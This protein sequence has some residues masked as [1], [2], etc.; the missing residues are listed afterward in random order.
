MA[1]EIRGQDD[2]VLLSVSDSGPGIPE[3]QREKIFGRVYRLAGQEVE[4]SGLGLSIVH[5]GG[6]I[7]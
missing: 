2:K 4:G 3:A 6:G 5:R 7:T 1:V